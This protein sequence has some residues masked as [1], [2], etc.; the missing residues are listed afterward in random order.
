MP[1]TE[2]VLGNIDNCPEDWSFEKREEMILR[3]VG[4]NIQI[5]DQ[6][7]ADD[8]S[9]TAESPRYITDLDLMEEDTDEDSID[10]PDEPEDGEEDDDEDP[11]ED[12]EEDPS[13]GHETE[14]DD[15]DDDMDDED[16]EPIED[17]EA[18]KTIRLEPPM[19]AFMEARIAE[20]VATPIPPTSPAYDQAPLGHRASMIR[21]RDDIP[22]EDMPPQRRFVLTAPPFGCDVVESSAATAARPPRCQ[23]DFVDTVEAGQG[24]IRSLGHDARTIARVDDRVDDVGYVRALQDS[25]DRMMTSIEEV[26]LRVNYQAQI[27]KMEKLESENVSLE[28]QVQS[29]IKERENVKSE[30]QKLFDSIK[31]TR[32]QTQGEIN[33]LIE[34]VNQKTYA[35]AEVRAQ[36]QDLLIMISELKAKL[37][38]VE[39]APGMYKV[40][41]KQEPNTERSKSVLPST[42][43]SVASSVRRSLNRDSPLKNSVLSNTKKSSE[44]VE[45]FVKTNKKTYVASKNIFSNKKIITDVDVKNTIKVKDVLCVSCAKNVLI[46]CHD[47]CIANYKLNVHL[48]VRRALFT[49]PR[50]VKS[51]FKD[52]TL[53]A[54]KSRFFVK[55]TQSKS[56]D[57]TPKV[58]KTKI[59]GVTPLSAQ[60]KVVQIVLL[61]VDSGCSKYKMGDQGDDLLT[62]AHK[63]NLYTISISDMAASS[64]VFLLSKTTSTKSWLTYE[65][66]FEKRSSNV[67]I[68]SAAQQVYNHEDSP[69]T[70]SITIE[71]HEAPPIDAP[72]FEEAGS[73]ITALDPSNMHEFHQVQPSTHIWTKSHPLEQYPKDSGF[74]L[75]AYSDADHAGCKD[76]CKSTSGGLQ[77]LG[78]KLM[79]WSSKKQYYIAMSTAEAEYVSLSACCAQ[80]TVELYFVRTEYQPADLFTKALPKER[81]EYLVHCIGMRRIVRIKRLLSA[82]EVT[83]ASY[84]F[85]CCSEVIEQTY[86]RLQKLISQLEMHG[87]V[88]PQED[89]NQK[90]LRRLSQE[91]TMHTIVWRNKPEIETLSLDDLSTN[92]KAL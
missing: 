86:E 56:L 20:H 28:F 44:K 43:L 25:E 26:N 81:F 38:K 16:E 79:S 80:G 29:L 3:V 41:K 17:E 92:R 88:I 73:F 76:D 14:D 12:P 8:A 32:T 4:K 49:T 58:S 46:P 74:E 83:T 64:P 18:W 57:T 87:E 91:W 22:E 61:I 68:N 70:S 6:P 69:L 75:I 85:Y 89:I 42:R 71:E 82:V 90:F 40:T 72:T 21:M 33:E 65:E 30:Y 2:R 54:S 35:Y 47:K 67:S 5:E 66:Y 78:E 48:K 50:T 23:Y 63:S 37:K 62:G 84:D 15:D 9:L 51:K 60:N 11:E 45:V 53:V 1:P 13:E 55:T 27:S 52:T 36:N 39:K 77:I 7:Y 34:H 24:L 59:D 10:C 31:K 19:S